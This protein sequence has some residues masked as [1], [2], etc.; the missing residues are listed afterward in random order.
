MTAE[1]FVAWEDAASGRQN[2]DRDLELVRS[3]ANN[4]LAIAFRFYTWTPWTVSLGKHQSASVADSAAIRDRGYDVVHRPTGGRAVFHAQEVTYAC[5]VRR[6][7]PQN[8]YGAIHSLLLHA[9]RPLIP[10]EPIHTSSP[11]RLHEH[12]ASAGPLGASCFTAHARTEITVE[13]RKLVGSAQRVIDD[14]ILQHGSILCGPAH[15]E[16]P[17][18][19]LLSTADRQRLQQALE[20]SSTSLAEV[21]SPLTH[22]ADVAQQ[23]L[24]TV[25][26]ANLERY[27]LGLDGLG[28]DRPQY[29]NPRV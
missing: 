14:V 23:L 6:S 12:Y 16:L 5:A 28:L 26:P 19:L 15:L 1:I 24:T 27:V 21:G 25:T 22:P 2:M 9:L 7:S 29:G 20:R 4:A 11:T 13:G 8:V 10:T 3:V 17:E 18:L